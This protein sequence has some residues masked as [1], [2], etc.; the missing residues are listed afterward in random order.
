MPTRSRAF[1]AVVIVGASV[2]GIRCAMTLRDV[3]YTG[4]IT[5]LESE[6]GDPYDKPQL[7]KH[8]APGDELTPLASET[9][10]RARDIDFRPGV[11]ATALDVAARVLE[12]SA[13]PVEYDNVVIATGCRPRALA[14]P[15]PPRATYIRSK[16]DWKRLRRGIAPG[17]RLIVVG[18]G[19]LGLEAA[20]A[21]TTLGISTTVVDVAPRVLTRGIPA[22]AAAL[23]SDR[24]VSEGVELRLGV[25]PPVLSGDG[26]T[27]A[28]D[29]VEG[30]C[31]V[32]A[33][34][35]VPNVE[36][37]TG[38]GLMLEDGVVCDDTL[39]A[40]P[41]VWAAGDCARWSNPRYGAVERVEHWTTAVNQAKHVA[42]SIASGAPSP[43]GDVPYVWSDQFDWK[44]QTVGHPGTDEAHYLSATG[45]HVVVSSDHGTVTGV[46]T[47]NAQALCLR[48][49]QVLQ[50]GDVALEHMSELLQ[51]ATLTGVG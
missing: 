40:A 6:L 13:G 8:L 11:A 15:L 20:A 38:S 10:L 36:W 22:G 12:T 26:R 17:G 45:G 30:D 1:G 19:F 27:V 48:S 18:A 37:L 35:A 24:H 9:A 2:A 41:G 32:V 25:S 46:T 31:A 33:V 14:T 3:A 16:E 23:I 28:I 42:G 49:R 39:V 21:A 47:I 29:G 51:L 50:R 34:G 5:L 7:S 44:I 43:F 4:A